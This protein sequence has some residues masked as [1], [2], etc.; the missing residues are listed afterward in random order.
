LAIA[1]C[2]TRQPPQSSPL[3]PADA[4]P[5]SKPVPAVQA[6]PVATPTHSRPIDCPA[7]RPEICTQQYQPVC[8]TVDTGVRCIKAPCPSEQ[9]KE[10]SNWCVA[11]TDAKVRSYVEG[12]CPGGGPRPSPDSMP[13]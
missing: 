11:C 2:T 10:Y 9:W 12:P 7:K 3:V 8:A 13:Q 6:A 5:P 4:P 1:A